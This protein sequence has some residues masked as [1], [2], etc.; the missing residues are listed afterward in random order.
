MIQIFLFSYTWI[1]K[2]HNSLTSL[3]DNQLQ[4]QS[5]NQRKLNS[6]A[7]ELIYPLHVHPPIVRW[8]RSVME[9]VWLLS[10]T[11]VSICETLSMSSSK[12]KN[13]KCQSSWV[14]TNYAHQTWLS[15]RVVKHF[16]IAEQTWLQLSINWELFVRRNFRS[17]GGIPHNNLFAVCV[18]Y[19]CGNKYSNSLLL[20]SCQ[21]FCQS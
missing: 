5:N 16:S 15:T 8:R 2:L 18:T 4:Q 17:K 13:V 12:S 14:L 10:L 21:I 3:G 7:L 9:G 19:I 20:P 11:E 6:S 1:I